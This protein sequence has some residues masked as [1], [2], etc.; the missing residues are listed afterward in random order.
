MVAEDAGDHAGASRWYEIV[1]ATDRAFTSATFG[2]SRC[3]DSLGRRNDAAGALARVPATSGDHTD[4]TIA[5]ARLLL[6]ADHPTFVDVTAAAT[7]ADDAGLGPEDRARLR[8]EVFETAIRVVG[9]DGDSS[10]A[11]VLGRRATDR[12]LR[13][14]LEAALRDLARRATTPAERVALVER[15][16][17]RRPKSLL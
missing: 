13:L 9:R 2:L 10:S 1:S 4:A 7:I 3:F 17:R 12:Q 16:N 14:G 15:A 6:A 8:V 11:T 5:R